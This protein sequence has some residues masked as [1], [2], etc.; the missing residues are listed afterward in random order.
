MKS[1][2]LAST[3]AKLALTKK[4]L[5]VVVMDLRDVT[6]MTDFFVV[7]SAESDTQ[8]KA[9]ADAVLDGTEEKGMVPWNKETGSTNWVLLD[10]SDVVLHIFH[11]N[12]RTFYNLEKLWGDA[13]MKWVRDEKTAPPKRP[14]T[15]TLV[16]PSPGK[17]KPAAKKKAA[18]KKNTTSRKRKAS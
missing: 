11:K 13:K 7:C 14:K 3:I 16:K 12:A 15:S 4:A 5:D 8:I 17:K 18:L 1:T 10:Y 6:S 9:I 2:Q